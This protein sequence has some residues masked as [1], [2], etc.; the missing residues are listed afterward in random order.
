[1]MAPVSGS[2]GRL[3]SMFSTVLRAR[4]SRTISHG[5]PP[6]LAWA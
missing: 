5:A 4:V 3:R 6:S 2:S 1:M